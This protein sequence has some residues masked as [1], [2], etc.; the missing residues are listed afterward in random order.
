[1]RKTR[2][3]TTSELAV[4]RDNAARGAE[5]VAELLGRSVASVRQAAHR[6]RIS[7][8]KHGSRKGLVLGQPRG[9]SLRADLRDGLVRD[10]RDELLERRAQADAA[11]ELC[12]CC[13]RRP[14][15]TRS[16]FCAA[17]TTQRITERYEELT[18]DDDALRRLWAAR[19][20]RKAILDGMD[21]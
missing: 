1:M 18:A 9:V 14:A 13:G 6:H 15:R 8:R 2:P 10:R 20:R 3:W 5:A 16:G 12:P 17:C 7:L 19:Q 21:A 4:M 11:A